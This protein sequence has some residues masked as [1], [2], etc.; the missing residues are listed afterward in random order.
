[1]N[2]AWGAARWRDGL[3]E[4]GEGGRSESERERGRGRGRGTLR[5]R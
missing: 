3:R 2:C 4:G 1:M 5:V